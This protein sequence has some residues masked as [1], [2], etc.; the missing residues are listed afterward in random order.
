MQVR[1]AIAED[2]P[3]YKDQARVFHAASPVHS[4]IDFDDDGYANFYLAA[5]T[6]PDIGMWLAESEDKV[7]GI[8][9]ALM[10]PIYFSPNTRVAQELWWWLTPDS[11]GTGAGAAMFAQIEQWAVEQ[12]A[13]AIF[14]IA[15]E[16]SRVDSMVKVYGRAGYRPTERTFMK[17]M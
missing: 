6:N 1:A 17:E 5:L 16:D 10:Y 12:K 7:V 14:M 13:Q 9:G 15:L 3:K 4:A 11:R 8:A 2:L